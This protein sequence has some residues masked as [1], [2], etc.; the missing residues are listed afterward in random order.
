MQY[1]SER[2]AV[3]HTSSLVLSMNHIFTKW[4][5]DFEKRTQYCSGTRT[6]FYD[7]AGRYLPQDAHSIVVD[8]GCGHGQF[9]RHLHLWQRYA[10]LYLLDANEATVATLEKSAYYKAPSTLPFAN[11]TVA[12]LHCSHLIEHLSPQDLYAF[13][14]EVDRVLAPQGI[15]VISSPLLWDRFY[16]DLSHIKPYNP[17]VLIK[18][19]CED[20]ALERTLD[21]IANAIARNYRVEELVYRYRIIRDES[22]GS[23]YFIMDMCIRLL[24]SL[25]FNFGLRRY[26][27]NG[28]TLIVRKT[29]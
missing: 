13:L 14:Q 19:L 27:K 24:Q 10:N 17:K 20:D 29:A 16:D 4:K 25:I 6:P 5:T 8:V 12:Y 22:L 28:Y 9:A 7:L 15:A 18:Y 1:V 11:T 21:R 2:I 3:S 26:Q 23:P